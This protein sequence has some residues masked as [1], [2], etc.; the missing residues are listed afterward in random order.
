MASIKSVT[1]EHAIWY[2]ISDNAEKD[3]E[4]FSFSQKKLFHSQEIPLDGY[5]STLS[6]SVPLVMPNVRKSA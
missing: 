3:L 6:F 1:L 4:G 5:S 2:G